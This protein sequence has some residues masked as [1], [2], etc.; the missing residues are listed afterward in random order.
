MSDVP[1]S[2]DAVELNLHESAVDDS[3]FDDPAL[4]P[5]A[6]LFAQRRGAPEQAPIAVDTAGGVDGNLDDESPASDPAAEPPA[7]PPAD[8]GSAADG[9]SPEQT[10]ELRTWLDRMQQIPRERVAALDYFL[11]TGQLPADLAPAAPA[12]APA[13]PAA[14]PAA[15]A[16]PLAGI[17]FRALEDNLGR[18][19]ADAIRA[20]AERT[21]AQEAEVAR[22]REMVQQQAARSLEAQQQ[23]LLAEINA[24]GQAFAQQYGLDEHGVDEIQQRAVQLGVLPALQAQGLSV[25]DSVTRAMELAMRDDPR[26]LDA[27]VERLVA[28]KL[29]AAQ[30]TSGRRAERRALA[31]QVAGT[32]GTAPRSAAPITE[33]Q[34]RQMSPDERREAMLAEARQAF[35]AQ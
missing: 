30:E 8:D 13:A 17:D 33:A 20:L 9:W 16:D 10:A 4:A 7:T 26:W 29:N 34:L 28:E 18:E 25:R 14:A 32:A 15:P 6:D 2:L 12:P 1:P 11:A 3:V 27:H 21:A 5:Y 22:A 24:A 19:G 35:S 31:A 23:Q